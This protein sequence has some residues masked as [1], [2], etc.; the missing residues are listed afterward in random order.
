VRA[1]TTP[2]SRLELA[3]SRGMLFDPLDHL[4]VGRNASVN[5]ATTFW[6]L[7][8]GLLRSDIIKKLEVIDLCR[9]WLPRARR[10]LRL[11]LG[12]IPGLPSTTFLACQSTGR[13]PTRHLACGSMRHSPTT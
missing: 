8:K 5:A 11:P 6:F 13:T 2:H 1:P 9:I 4:R 7:P 10:S 3:T 12:L